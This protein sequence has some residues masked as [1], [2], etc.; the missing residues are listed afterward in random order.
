MG[1]AVAIR[2]CTVQLIAI[3]RLRIKLCSQDRKMGGFDAV[4]V[5]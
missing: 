5:Y 4:G 1:V 2:W 3:N